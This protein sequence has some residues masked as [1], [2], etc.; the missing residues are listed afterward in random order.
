MHVYFFRCLSKRKLHW[1]ASKDYMNPFFRGPIT[2]H[3]TQCCFGE[4]LLATQCSLHFDINLGKMK[5]IPQITLACTTWFSLRLHFM[6]IS[7]N[8]AF[9]AYLPVHCEAPGMDDIVFALDAGCP[10]LHMSEYFSLIQYTKNP[11]PICLVQEQML[12]DGNR[13]FYVAERRQLRP[14]YLTT[15]LES[16]CLG[17]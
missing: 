10:W 6:I 9:S 1:V 12:Q 8:W 16:Y 13:W 7:S 14:R 11:H 5:F 15:G 4:T 17:V 2:L 3:A